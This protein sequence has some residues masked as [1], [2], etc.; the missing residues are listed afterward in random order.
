MGMEVSGPRVLEILGGGENLIRRN[1]ITCN[2]SSN[3]TRIIKT[4]MGQA[5]HVAC[6][7]QKSKV[8]LW[9]SQQGFYEYLDVGRRIML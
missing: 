3:K 6:M 1:F 7:G 2:F 8:V 9:E 4:R 5:G